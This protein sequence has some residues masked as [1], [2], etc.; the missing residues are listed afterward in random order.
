METAPQEQHPIEAAMAEAASL[1]RV[2]QIAADCVAVLADK[3]VTLEEKMLRAYM[4]NLAI[5]SAQCAAK[6]HELTRDG[7]KSDL[8]VFSE[9]SA[10]TEETIVALTELLKV[11]RYDL[12]FLEQ[13]YEHGFYNK[14]LNEYRFLER[15]ESIRSKLDASQ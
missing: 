7:A 1:A 9:L 4:H 2:V 8:E 14:L 6:L 12:N 13:Y 15:L 10:V 5:V 3:R 11:S